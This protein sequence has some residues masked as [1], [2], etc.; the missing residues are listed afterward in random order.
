MK[1]W[2]ML[3][4][5]GLE[6]KAAKAAALLISNVHYNIPFERVAEKAGIE[7][8]EVPEL[9]DKLNA[10]RLVTIEVN[11]KEKRGIVKRLL[12]VD[13]VEM[14]E[15]CMACYVRDAFGDDDRIAFDSFTTYEEASI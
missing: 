10:F 11:G 4:A 1:N 3:K 8:T 14:A 7:V 2:K 5:M 15:N 13:I 6:K 12:C 9:V